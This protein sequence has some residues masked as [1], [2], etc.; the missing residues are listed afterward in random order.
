MNRLR[1]FRQTAGVILLAFAGLN[2]ASYFVL[3][4]H[5]TLLFYERG[6]DRIGF[7]RVIWQHGSEPSSAI[8][9]VYLGS[10]G[11]FDYGALAID[12]AVALVASLIVGLLALVM[13][14]PTAVGHPR[15]QAS[16]VASGPPQFSLRALLAVTAVVAI[17]F[18]CKR[19]A[20]D[21]TETF[22]LAAIYLLGPSLLVVCAHITR[23]RNRAERFI[24]ICSALAILVGGAVA[25]G[26]RTGM[27]DFTRALLGLYVYWTPQCVLFL[28]A[29]AMWRRLV[30]DRR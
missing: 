6:I 27:A 28:A 26:V 10:D 7:P 23:G 30:G 12:A 4:Q 29:H 8:A 9:L 24:A 5:G 22:S 21:R 1:R 14:G 20:T 25:T 15:A 17:A 3:S 19:A 2:A 13:T 18:A 11:Y 16:A